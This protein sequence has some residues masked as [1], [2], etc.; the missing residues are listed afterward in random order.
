MSKIN[1]PIA[2]LSLTISVLLWAGIYNSENR[3]PPKPEQ[4]TF[5]A[6]LTP[7]NLDRRKFVATNIPS[8]ISIS[9]AGTHDEIKNVQPTAIVDLAGATKEKTS[10]PVVVFPTSVRSLMTSEKI[11]A[12]INIDTVIT[13]QV[14]VKGTLTGLLPNGKRVESIEVFPKKIYVTGASAD[15][16]RVD[17][18]QVPV[19]YAAAM[20]TEGVD[21][22]ARAVDKSGVRI[23]KIY[24]NISDPNPEFIPEALEI[25][26]L[27]HVRVKFE[28]AIPTGPPFK[29]P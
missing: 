23:P 1:I 27:I 4:K 22:E 29:L 11:M 12:T 19:D 14:D 20:N 24:M 18:V 15:V 17:S 10:Y 21:V 26:L 2:L 13:K 5:S 16:N 8:D 6:A 3:K 25:P 28:S 9:I 7:T